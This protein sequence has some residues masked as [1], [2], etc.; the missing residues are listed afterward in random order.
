MVS[1]FLFFTQFLMIVS[2]PRS[3]SATKQILCRYDS[4]LPV[5][6]G[7]SLSLSYLRILLV[8]CTKVYYEGPN[9]RNLTSV[10][11]HNEQVNKSYHRQKFPFSVYSSTL[12]FKFPGFT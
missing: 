9:E 10:R 5:V 2:L 3:T 1:A 11:V 7:E 4:G 6:T 12:P 8:L